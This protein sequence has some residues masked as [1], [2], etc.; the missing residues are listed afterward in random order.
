MENLLNKIHH[1]DCLD[2]TNELSDNSVDLV[3]TDPPYGDGVG[4]GRE[5]KEIL[6]NETPEINKLIMPQLYRVLKDDSAC[7]V[8]SNWKFCHFVR[9]WAEEVGFTTKMM[10][11]IVKNNIGMGG[12]F[13][14]QYEVCWVFEKGKPE[15]N[16]WTS[17]IINMEHI[18]HDENSHPHQK[19]LQLIKRL[20]KLGL[21]R[22]G[23]VLDCFSGSGSTAIACHDLGFDFIAIEKDENYFKASSSRLEEHRK[24]LTLF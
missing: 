24:Q 9:Q 11:I 16:G 5:A 1:G 21:A 10:L 17:N 12:A 6:S 2:F 23:V 7:F 19:G 15:Y 14:N 4:Y 3:L 13:R 20:L 8:F 22:G 18:Q